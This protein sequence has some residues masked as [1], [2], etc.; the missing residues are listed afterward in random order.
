MFK[1]QTDLSQHGYTASIL[2]GFCPV[3]VGAKIG[4][5]RGDGRNNETHRAHEPQI[6]RRGHLG[7][8][9]GDKA[10]WLG[11]GLSPGKF[12]GIKIK[13]VALPPDLA[14]ENWSRLLPK[15]IPLQVLAVCTFCSAARFIRGPHL[16]AQG[17]F[18]T[19][20]ENVH[21]TV[22]FAV[23]VPHELLTSVVRRPYEERKRSIMTPTF[24]NNQHVQNVSAR[25]SFLRVKLNVASTSAHLHDVRVRSMSHPHADLPTAMQMFAQLIVDGSITWQTIPVDSE[26]VQGFPTWKLTKGTDLPGSNHAKNTAGYPSS[27]FR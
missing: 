6:Q 23:T 5:D 11:H 15:N 12:D 26:N 25:A 7:I 9:V 8:V 22:R 4:V 2:Y 14:W 19:R 3:R 16:S 13:P 24:V 10:T 20:G 18:H 17:A 21:L 1:H 27:G